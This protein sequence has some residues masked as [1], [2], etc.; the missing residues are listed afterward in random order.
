M[1]S[2][3][4]C[5]LFILSHIGRNIFIQND[6]DSYY[7][8]FTLEFG[9]SGFGKKRIEIL[10]FIKRTKWNGIHEKNEVIRF[11]SEPINCSN[12]GIH[13]RLH[14][15]HKSVSSMRLFLGK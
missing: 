10:R 11:K 6:H 7:K 2:C 9:C 1:H 14:L 12:A 13:F 15:S 5:C 8:K 3:N 4:L